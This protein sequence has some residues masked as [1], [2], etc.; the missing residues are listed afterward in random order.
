MNSQGSRFLCDVPLTSK[1]STCFLTDF[2][3]QVCWIHCAPQLFYARLFL[4][5]APQ[6]FSA[7][8]F[9]SIYFFFWKKKISFS[10]LHIQVNGTMRYGNGYHC[11]IINGFLE[12]GNL[13][14]VSISPWTRMMRDAL[15]IVFVYLSAKAE[16]TENAALSIFIACTDCSNSS[17]RVVRE[18]ERERG[19]LIF[20]KDS[21][22]PQHRRESRSV[23]LSPRYGFHPGSLQSQPLKRENARKWN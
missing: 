15:Y 5:C 14:R 22:L 11:I 1:N 13:T 21:S 3:F 18:S 10:A 19:T 23:A 16:K 7:R 20:S 6:L 9:L 8:L 12:P 17:Q 4:Y 2:L